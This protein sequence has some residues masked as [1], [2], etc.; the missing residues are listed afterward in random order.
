MNTYIYT[1]RNT[2]HHINGKITVYRIKKNAPYILGAETEV[3]YRS[4]E[5]AVCDVILDNEK[6]WGKRYQG[7]HGAENPVNDARRRQ[8]YHEEGRKIQLFRVGG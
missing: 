8:I 4:I 2:A 7:K 1:H 5:Q 3:G 6:G